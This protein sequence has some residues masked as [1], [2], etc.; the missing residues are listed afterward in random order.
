MLEAIATLVSV[1]QSS[2]PLSTL[3]CYVL[4][5]SSAL[6]A[7]DMDHAPSELSAAVTEVL[8][9]ASFESCYV[10]HLSSLTDGI[11]VMIKHQRASA[12]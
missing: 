12:T 2:K 11:W 8:F 10:Y 1:T 7:I 3:S 5:L 4:T 9:N 6:T